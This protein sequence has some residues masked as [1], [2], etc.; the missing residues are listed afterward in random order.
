MVESGEANYEIA[1]L[2]GKAIRH[3]LD[4]VLS[5]RLALTDTVP[6]VPLPQMFTASGLD[7]GMQFLE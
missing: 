2:G 4:R 1:Q 7:D 5:E 3:V 6:Q